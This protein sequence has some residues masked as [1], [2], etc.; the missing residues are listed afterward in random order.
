[1]SAVAKAYYAA[2][3]A[4]ENARSASGPEEALDC[5]LDAMAWRRC[6]R[7][8]RRAFNALA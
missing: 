1:M 8:M 2:R 4:L 5:Y 6:A 3:V 7:S